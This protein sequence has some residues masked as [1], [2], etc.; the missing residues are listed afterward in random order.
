MARQRTGRIDENILKLM[1][2]GGVDPAQGSYEEGQF[3]RAGQIPGAAYATGPGGQSILR[4]G[5]D[6]SLFIPKPST[7]PVSSGIQRSMATTSGATPTEPSE[8]QAVAAQLGITSPS[9]LLKLK[10]DMAGRG[11]GLGRNREIRAAQGAVRGERAQAARQAGMIE[12]ATAPARIKE[13]GLARRERFAAESAAAVQAGKN[14]TTITVAEIGAGTAEAATKATL[15]IA[16]NKEFGLNDRDAKRIALEEAK[17]N[18]IAEEQVANRDAAGMKDTL[19]AVVKLFKEKTSLAISGRQTGTDDAGK[20][21]V[22]AEPAPTVAGVAAEVGQAMGATAQSASD[23]ATP[24]NGDVNGDGKVD[25]EDAKI[26]SER[27]DRMRVI[28]R[29]LLRGDLTDDQMNNI[30][31]EQARLRAIKVG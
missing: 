15:E 4:P 30:K 2:T 17:L 29:L 13:E 5:M 26:V 19:D 18:Q 20:P 16:A 14:L 12:R 6:G 21:I 10:S 31:K 22:A 1:A 8:F 25:A 9:G 28:N 27:D 7:E 24:V 3:R 23:G 11:A